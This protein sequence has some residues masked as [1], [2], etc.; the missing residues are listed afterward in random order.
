[1]RSV[2]DPRNRIVLVIGSILIRAL[3]VA[4]LGAFPGCS[5][6]GIGG[7]PLSHRFESDDVIG[8]IRAHRIRGGET[9]LDLTRPYELGYVELVAANPGIDPWIPGVGTRVVLPTAH[10][11]PSGPREGI[12]I[13]LAD[14]RLYFFGEGHAAGEGDRPDPGVSSFP[15]GVGRDGWATPLGST[16]IVRK[17]RDPI[18]YPTRSAREEDPDL[19]AAVRAGPENPL[20]NRALYLGWPTYLIHG[21]NEPDGVGRRVSRGC[22]RL[23]PE[24]ILR[25]FDETAVDTPVRVVDEPVKL[26]W[27]GHDVYL[28]VHPT[29]DEM[30][31]IEEKGM[32]EPIRPD[33]LRPRIRK[34]AGAEQSRIDW[35][36]AYR[37]AAERRGIPVRITH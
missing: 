15:I 23:Y 12:V 25:L 11:L 13:N 37:V 31:Q 10:V 28:E 20:G 19:P 36:I 29:L 5:T 35:A 7:D 34:F 9:L 6:I 26:G 14:Q 2:P 18:W 1:M 17:R 27:V 16:R 32:L 24:G 21:T 33:D 22:I 4:F 8:R 30:G 3:S